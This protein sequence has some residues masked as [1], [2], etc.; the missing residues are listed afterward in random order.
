V[1]VDAVRT[2]IDLRDADANELPQT[3]VE[4]H[5]I[6]LFGGGVVKVRERPR[7]AGGT[8]VEFQSGR[9]RNPVRSAGTCHQER[10]LILFP[11]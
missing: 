11:H 6:E 9:H 8:S 3:G 10:H 4:A 1:H 5:V 7:E 2:T